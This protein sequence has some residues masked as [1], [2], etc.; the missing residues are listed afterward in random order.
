MADA[1]EGE[2]AAVVVLW[3]L[4]GV[5]S[6]EEATR[7]GLGCKATASVAPAYGSMVIQDDITVVATFASR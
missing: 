4:R 5:R 6:A 7:P 1:V 2:F 3:Q